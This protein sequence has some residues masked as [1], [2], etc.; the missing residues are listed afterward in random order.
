MHHQVSSILTILLAIALPAL[1]YGILRPRRAPSAPLAGAERLVYLLFLV[2]LALLAWSSLVMF[3][4]GSD[5]LGWMLV[6]HMTIAPVFC[7][8]VAGLSLIWSSRRG[9]LCTLIVLASALVVIVSALLAMMSWFGSDGQRSLLAV[10]RVAS[11]I[12]VVVAAY[13]ATRALP[14]TAAPV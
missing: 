13:Q 3:A 6:L 8:A 4:V 11:M 1:D 14:K 7:V 2:T 12:L 9:S 5:M 10:H